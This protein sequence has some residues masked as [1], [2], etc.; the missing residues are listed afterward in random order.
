M[1]I[2]EKVIV[3][4]S[5]G[6]DSAVAALLLKEQG[7]RVEGLFMKNWEEDDS[8]EYCSA[9]KDLAD[10]QDIAERLEI[11]LHTVNFSSDYWD[12]V[13]EHFLAEYRAG[14]TPNPDVLCN[15]EIKFKAFLDYALAHLGGRSIA[16]G[17][18]AR[19]VGVSRAFQLCRAADEGK[20]QTYFL[21]M[22]NQVQLAH[23]RFPL[24]TTTKQ[25]VRE[26]ARQAG[27]KVHDKKDS[28][29]I[30][31]IGER[32]FQEFLSRFLPAQP[33]PIETPGGRL[34]G[35]HQGLMY[36]TLGQRKGLRV[37]GLQEADDAP[38]FVVAKDLNRNTLVVAQGHE[39]PL[40][41]KRQ[42]SISQLHW[43]AG[44]PPGIPMACLARVRHRQPLQQCRIITLADDRCEVEFD[45]PQR[46]LTPGQS[47][48]FYRGEACLGG[49]IMEHTR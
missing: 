35:E 12:R 10:A 38:W 9:A 45:H 23:S 5:G 47:A 34:I 1:P 49:G 4:L 32:R 14:R 2:T 28:T 48:V 6:V 22:L 11:P 36:Y 30:C 44:S 18:Y 7:Y 13:F 8:A 40:L 41:M 29:G 33:G 27:F 46:A 20:D 37:G 16:T 31:F 21:Y 24:G 25:Q 3:G 42:V 26:L 15:R 43:I 19:I 17:H 39:H